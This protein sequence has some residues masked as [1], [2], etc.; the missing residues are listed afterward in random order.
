MNWNEYPWINIVSIFIG[1]VIVVIQIL[2][3]KSTKCKKR[4]KN[5]VIGL[6]VFL[7]IFSTFGTITDEVTRN[8][9]IEKDSIRAV[10]IS[11]SIES[12]I[13]KA[14][15]LK[16]NVD[17]LNDVIVN[18]DKKTDS[19][20]ERIGQY[21]NSFKRILDLQDLNMKNLTGGDG[22]AYIEPQINSLDSAKSKFGLTRGG[23][24]TLV[25]LQIVAWTKTTEF[26][27]ILPSFFYSDA[28]KYDMEYFNGEFPIAIAFSALNGTWDQ[29][30]KYLKVEGNWE[31]C[32]YVVS[33]TDKHLKGKNYIFKRYVSNNFPENEL[34]QRFENLWIQQQTEKK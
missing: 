25:N 19:Q 9:E 1:T 2:D 10:N 12:S 27:E 15:L 18:V 8:K 11:K 3:C 28:S 21:S 30:I 24:N 34:I 32:Y 33:F 20:L 6:S 26:Q 16:T 13:K 14:E 4:K 22:Y 5:S 17:N 31:Y 7:M 23:T 29:I